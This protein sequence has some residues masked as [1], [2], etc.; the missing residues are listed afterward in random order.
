M[1][2][3]E[4]TAVGLRCFL[5]QCG[6][7]SSGRLGWM[8]RILT[9][10]D[11][12]NSYINL[13]RFKVVVSL[14]LQPYPQWLDPPNPPQPPSQEVLVVG[15]LGFDTLKQTCRFSR[16]LLF[17]K[18]LDEIAG[19]PISLQDINASPTKHSIKVFTQN[20]RPTVTYSKAS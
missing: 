13:C 15:A 18:K 16:V 10:A 6:L 19:S 1:K 17:H 7:C 9:Q 12:Q 5:Q 8:S 3:W 4:S 11:D 20:L 14:G 2:L